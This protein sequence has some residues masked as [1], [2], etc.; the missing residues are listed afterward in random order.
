MYKVTT[1]PP[2]TSLILLNW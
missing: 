1:S 2:P